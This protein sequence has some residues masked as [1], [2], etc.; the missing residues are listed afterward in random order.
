MNEER[1]KVEALLFASGNK[2]L[3]DDITRLC[4]LNNNQLTKRV[5]SELKKN[6]K[7]RN[8]PLMLV[9]ENDYW[10][11]TVR[12]EF[13]PLV[14]KIVADTE[15]PKSVTE[16]LAV[17]A[18]RSPIKQSKIIEIRSNKAYEHMSISCVVWIKEHIAI[19]RRFITR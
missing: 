12:E 17:I 8:S 9:D 7:D 1:N 2:L 3:T 5:L 15:L 19:S 10:K 18:W 13:L 4:E 16:T 11:L 14:R 6:L